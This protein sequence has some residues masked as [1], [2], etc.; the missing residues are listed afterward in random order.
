MQMTK[1]AAPQAR[2]LVG[3]DAWLGQLLG[4]FCPHAMKGYFLANH[5]RVAPR[6][7]AWIRV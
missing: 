2:D 5:Y 7:N 3:L 4:R 6:A 1:S